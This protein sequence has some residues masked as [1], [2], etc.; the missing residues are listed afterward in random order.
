MAIVRA[1]IDRNTV[2][3]TIITITETEAITATTIIL[4]RKDAVHATLI[5]VEG[6][7]TEGE[8]G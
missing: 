2:K 4:T 7:E 8:R 5:A 6:E 1:T 3:S